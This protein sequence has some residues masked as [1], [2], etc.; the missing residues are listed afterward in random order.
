MNLTEVRYN[1]DIVE[2]NFGIVVF[3][4]NLWVINC[5]LTGDENK[6]LQSNI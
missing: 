5:N 3:S 4:G 6:A 2:D 1:R